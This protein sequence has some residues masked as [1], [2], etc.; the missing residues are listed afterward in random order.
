[1]IQNSAILAKPF[2]PPIICRL[3]P[4][5]VR[6]QVFACGADVPP[7][8]GRSGL[9]SAA[10]RRC[11]AAGCRA[12]AAT[13]GFPSA[14]TAN[15]GCDGSASCEHGR[16]SVPAKKPECFPFGNSQS[17]SGSGR[18]RSGGNEGFVDR[19]N[20]GCHDSHVPASFHAFRHSGDYRILQFAGGTKNA[21]RDAVY[22]GGI[23]ASGSADHAKAPAGTG[24]ASGSG[25]RQVRQTD[26]SRFQVSSADTLS[27]QERLSF[28]H[29][30]ARMRNC[31]GHSVSP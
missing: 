13:D 12:N 21:A 7:A 17:G 3:E 27:S 29:E 30:V 31:S 28:L 26:G 24:S 11:H 2:P 4:L 14:S 1:M 6:D 18:I 8:C 22:D 25:C 9:F 10:D 16:P 19:R 23:D 20:M 5:P 15:V